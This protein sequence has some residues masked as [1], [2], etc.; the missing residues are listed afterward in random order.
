MPL[1]VATGNAGKLAEFRRLLVGVAVL[2]PADVGL[3]DLEVEETGAT[4]RDNALLKARTFAAAAGVVCVADDSGLE[5][6]ALDGRPGVHS[7]RYGGPGLDDAGRCARLLEE[8]DGV[9][10]RTA[11]FRC[12]LAVTDG[13][14]RLA[15]AEGACE[16]R[17]LPAPAGDGGFG[18]DPLFL[19]LEYGRS[20]AQLSSAEKNGVSHRGKALRS[21]LP[22]LHRVFPELA[23]PA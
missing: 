2:S 10:E 12:C 1:L 4:F 19:C 8:L 7:A 14:G 15:E 6:D 11:R 5:V 17:I 22:R 21:L 18:Y 9:A 13:A 23:V 20:M 16:G 3:A